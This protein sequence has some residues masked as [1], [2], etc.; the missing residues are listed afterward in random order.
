M[1]AQTEWIGT[2]NRCLWP[3]DI[4][5]CLY[6]SLLDDIFLLVTFA[7]TS[8]V[9]GL[10]LMLQSTLCI[11]TWSVSF[12]VYCNCIFVMIIVFQSTSTMLSVIRYELVLNSRN[13]N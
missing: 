11:S 4:V 6:H 5:S 8:G 7:R 3:V 1:D 2:D 9:S 10:L 13:C 12:T